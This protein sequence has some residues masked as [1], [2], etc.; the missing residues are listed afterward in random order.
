MLCRT[1]RT[2]H[3]EAEF[4]E[5]ARELGVPAEVLSPAETARWI[6]ASHFSV[7]GA[8]HFPRDCHLIPERYIAYLG[9]ALPQREA[10][11]STQLPCRAGQWMVVPARGSAPIGARSKATSSSFC[12][13]AWSAAIARDLRLRIPMQA[14]KGYS[15]TLPNP[16]ELPRLCSI[17]HR[18]ARR[19]HAEGTTL[20]V[21]G[22][23]E[24]A[25]IN[26]RI[27][28]AASKE[29]SKRFPAIT[30]RFGHSTS[31]VSNRGRD[32]ARVRLMDCLISAERPRPQT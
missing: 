21:G 26:S 18:S 24:L 4:A 5:Q 27:N 25:G 31:P 1:E 20:R 7:A 14:G 2:L 11:C 28:R 19:G 9:G 16:V 32:C 15:L 12:G 13:G 8:I 17:P 3:E 29:S 10:L 22:T 23:M 30:R 6:P